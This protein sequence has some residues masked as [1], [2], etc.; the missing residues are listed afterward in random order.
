LYD[1]QRT[2]IANQRYDKKH[3]GNAKAGEVETKQ[4]AEYFFDSR[5]YAVEDIK[6]GIDGDKQRGNQQ[7]TLKEISDYSSEA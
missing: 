2:Q 3:Y 4:G 1:N 5:I 7:Q 6:H